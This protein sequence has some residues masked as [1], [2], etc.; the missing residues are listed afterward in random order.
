[1]Q[2]GCAAFP[3]STA[4]QNTA[5]GEPLRTVTKHTVRLC[6]TCTDG[7]WNGMGIFGGLH[8]IWQNNKRSSTFAKNHLSAT[9]KKTIFKMGQIDAFLTCGYNLGSSAGLQEC[10]RRRDISLMV[11]LKHQQKWLKH[12][13]LQQHHCNTMHTQLSHITRVTI[14]LLTKN[15]GPHEKF[16]RTF[17]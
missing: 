11:S 7:R 15:P 8:F 17:P 1:M 9:Y 2:C 13:H 12:F 16:S 10:P 4:W 3:A 5:T 6:N 14:L